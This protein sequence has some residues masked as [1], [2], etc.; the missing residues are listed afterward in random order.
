MC[1]PCT[2]LFHLEDAKILCHSRLAQAKDPWI[3]GAMGWY[4]SF[5]SQATPDYW[6]LWLL[7]RTSWEA[8][9]ASNRE[10]GLPATV[11]NGSD[12]EPW[13]CLLLVCFVLFVFESVSLM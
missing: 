4:L 2:F 8:R 5:V 12:T 7:L 6:D 9:G 3:N 11:L 13:F 10:A 1:G